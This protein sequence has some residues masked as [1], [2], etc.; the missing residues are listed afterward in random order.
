MI[1]DLF[2]NNIT[3][4][5][6]SVGYWGIFFL[7]ALESTMFPL[8]S[9]LVMP[10]AGF[11]VANLTFGFW[12]VLIA[13][14]LGC[15]AGSLFSYYLGYYGGIPFVRKFGKYFLINE[16]HMK[17]SEEWFANKGDI[18]ILIGR[19]I[20]GIRHVISIPAGVSRM[21]VFEFSIFTVIGAGIWNAILIGLGYL[22]EKNWKLVYAY[23][24]YV[25]MFI[26]FI[27]AIALIYYITYVI[28]ER[29]KRKF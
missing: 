5:V 13:S 21:N 4:F 26:V 9:E 10:F 23:T 7:M 22:L 24:E 1:V 29:R 27:L 8:P 25:D 14:T 18:T 19:F 17:K 28:S 6:T 11:L 12:T 16:G 20:P 3:A 2:V 15:L